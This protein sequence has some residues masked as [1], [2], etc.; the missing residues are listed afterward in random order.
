LSDQELRFHCF[1]LWSGNPTGG[2]DVVEI[3]IA[4]LL[5][6]IPLA[7]LVGRFIKLGSPSP[8]QQKRDIN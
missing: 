8:E 3:I 6:Q 5:P 1:C 4:I 7:I 2:Y